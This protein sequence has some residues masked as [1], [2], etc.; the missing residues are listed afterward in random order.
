MIRRPPRSTLSSSSAAS[1]VYKRQILKRSIMENLL[2]FPIL[3]VILFFFAGI[4]IVRPTSRALVGRLGKYHRFANYG[5]NWIIPG[6]DRMFIINITE[7]MINAEPQEIITNDNL[8][9]K[10]DA[11]VYFK[12]KSDEV[13]VKNSQYNV[14]SIEYQNVNLARTTL[15]NII[16]TMTL[17]SA[18]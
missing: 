14:N 2:L 5:F 12:I 9:A 8:N 4:R 6:I 10:V 3:A 15:R 1:D 7:Q 17:K 16:G 18:N 13:S 11:Q